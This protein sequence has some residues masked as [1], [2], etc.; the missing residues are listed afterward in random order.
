MESKA[1]LAGGEYI[2]FDEDEGMTK[3]TLCS[4]ILR[5]DSSLI[6]HMRAQKH[7]H[8]YFVRYAGEFSNI[9]MTRVKFQQRH[10]P[11]MFRAIQRRSKTKADVNKLI[12][13]NLDEQMRI[14]GKREPFTHRAGYYQSRMSRK[15]R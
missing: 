10:F 7:V 11:E 8:A 13:K 12:A 15:V 2:V 5:D 14:Y 9:I 1:R 3:C 4:N 6:D